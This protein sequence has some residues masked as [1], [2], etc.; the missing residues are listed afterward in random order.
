MLEKNSIF[1]LVLI[2]LMAIFPIS[3]SF[4]EKKEGQEPIILSQLNWTG[5]EAICEVMKYVLENKLKVPVNISKLSIQVT[6][7]GLD[8]GDVD[9]YSDLWLPEQE[10]AV[11]KYVKLKKTVELFKSYPKAE[12]GFFIP[13]FVSKEYSIR[14]IEDLKKH[15]EIFDLDHDDI[16]DIWVGAVGWPP[17]EINRIKLRCYGINLKPYPVEEWVFLTKLKEAM[18][19]KAPIIFY[20][21]TPA[22]IFVK[23]DLTLIKEPKY[24]PKKWKYIEGDLENS[25]ITCAYPDNDVYVGV[26]VKL[27]N[28][29]LKA[30][31]FFKNWYIPIDE[32]NYL[33]T[34]IEDVP[35]NPK[36]EPS[37][38]AKKWVDDH[39]QIVNEWIKG[40][41]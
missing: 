32:V 14:D 5:S 21:W 17:D 37:K 3:A 23:Y 28:K 25:F 12:Q 38:V 4:A 34:E 41:K 30:Y 6:W 20:Y 33:I 11:E 2:L 24:D 29:S 1:I 35:D 36:K 18:R 19:K 15:S 27:K 16:G 10:K 13:T 7:A 8:K 31:E 22:W 39:S 40:I 26:S 9:I